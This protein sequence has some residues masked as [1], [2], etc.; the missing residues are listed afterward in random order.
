MDDSTRDLLTE[1]IEGEFENLHST[2]DE[3]KKTQIT[4]NLMALYR[5]KIE[6]DK[7]D[8]E[9]YKHQDRCDLEKSQ[10][11]IDVKLREK[12]LELRE[13][14]LELREKQLENEANNKLQEL[15]LKKT[16]AKEQ[17]IDRIFNYGVQVGLTV[18]GLVA[19]DVWNR[20]G[21]RFEETGTITSK[22]T[23]NLMS[24]MLPKK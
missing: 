6:E 24:K 9:Y 3:A 21:L 17:R 14:D 20:R 4:N 8:T 10:H 11:E 13:K 2:L 16:Q 5:L 1:A 7:T 23:Q 18:M 12:D 15:D 19:Y 22:I